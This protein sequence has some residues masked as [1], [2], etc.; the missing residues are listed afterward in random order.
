MNKTQI[1]YFQ[2]ALTLF[3]IAG[4]IFSLIPLT[5]SV[6]FGLV[7][8]WFYESITSRKSS[9]LANKTIPT[10]TSWLLYF[11]VI[12][13]FQSEFSEWVSEIIYLV[14]FLVTIVLFFSF[15]GIDAEE[16]G[17]FLLHQVIS[18]GVIIF[19][20][21]DSF[22]TNKEIIIWSLL[23]LYVLQNIA[24]F[25]GVQYSNYQYYFKF[26]LV[27]LSV[28][29]I[30]FMF[31][32]DLIN[33]LIAA[34]G[35]AIFS[36]LFHDLVMKLRYKDRSDASFDTQIYVHDFLISCLAAFYISNF[37]SVLIGLF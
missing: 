6:L 12:V 23:L 7:G 17:D 33:S 9:S 14:T 24:M 16:F 21:S 25:L 34:L 28:A 36:V 15:D 8:L 37:T 32:S 5:Y 2:T 26:F 11:F 20:F 3:L 1:R 19:I 10:M 35:V 13:T 22:Y 31:S 30:S 27:F 29:S 4:E 18:L